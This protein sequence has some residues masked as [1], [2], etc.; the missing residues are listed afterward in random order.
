MRAA[1]YRAITDFVAVEGR[2]AAK[3]EL[4]AMPVV[5]AG[6]AI[7]LTLLATILET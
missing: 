1:I 2:E 6:A 7:L 4:L 3:R 5:L